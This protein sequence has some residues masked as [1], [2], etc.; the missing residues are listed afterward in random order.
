[1]KFVMP[2]EQEIEIITQLREQISGIAFPQHVIDLQHARGKI[3]VPTYHW[4][5]D[6]TKIRDFDQNWFAVEE[7]VMLSTEP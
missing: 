6:L 7:R 3:L 1:M 2:L 4:I 5:T